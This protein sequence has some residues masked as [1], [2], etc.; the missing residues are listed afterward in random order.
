M[1]LPTELFISGQAHWMGAQISG[2]AEQAR[3]QP[4]LDHFRLGDSLV[5]AKPSQ[6]VR[7]ALVQF[8]LAIT[9]S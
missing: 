8:F 6:C 1:V 4:R 9:I 3:G 7:R 2:Q 5:H